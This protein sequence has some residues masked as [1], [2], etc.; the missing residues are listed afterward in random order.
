VETFVRYWSQEMMMTE[1]RDWLA[2]LVREAIQDL[3]RSPDL[4][5]R[6]PHLW[7]RVQELRKAEEEKRLRR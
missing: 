5:Q 7:K 3:E 4:Q 6:F 1:D 2:P